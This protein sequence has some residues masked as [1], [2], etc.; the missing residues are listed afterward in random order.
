MI[1]FKTIL[2]YRNRG[3]LLDA[4]VFLFQLLLIRVLTKLAVSFFQQ[5]EDNAFAK[6]FIG[7]FFVGLF[8]LQP[9]GPVL[10]RWTFHQH[11]K[12]FQRE[13]G[14]VTSFLLSIYRFFYIAVM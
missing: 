2:E 8:F 7:L 4:M 9:L 11:F 1:E 12:T 10:K 6:T 14:G 3:L 13:V 5:A